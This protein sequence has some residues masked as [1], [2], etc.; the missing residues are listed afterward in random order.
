MGERE[1][2]RKEREKGEINRKRKIK[3]VVYSEVVV[4][5]GTRVC[6]SSGL[7]AKSGSGDGLRVVVGLELVVG[8]APHR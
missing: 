5:E 6:R 4:E 1:K 3:G 7:V 2:G 8:V